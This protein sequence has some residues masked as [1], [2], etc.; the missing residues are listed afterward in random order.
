MTFQFLDLKWNFFPILKLILFPL[1]VTFQAISPVTDES[2]SCSF[3]IHVRDPI[4]PRVYN[5]PTDFDVYLSEGETEK[6]VRV[7]FN[8]GLGINI[9]LFNLT[10]K[11]KADN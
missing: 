4:P 3:T 6:G 5:C 1:Q 2:A 10:C 9:I 11:G 8:K 7:C